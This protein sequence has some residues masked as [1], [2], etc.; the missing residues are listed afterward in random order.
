VKDRQAVKAIGRVK[1]SSRCLFHYCNNRD[2][3]NETEQCAT[4]WDRDPHVGSVRLVAPTTTL[5]TNGGFK[6]RGYYLVLK[7]W[8]YR[9]KAVEAR[10][11]RTCAHLPV[12]FFAHLSPSCR[13]GDSRG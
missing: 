10:P 1:T 4:C 9:R 7:F 12:G 3:T 6:L 11:T 8:K 5:A 13:R 2:P